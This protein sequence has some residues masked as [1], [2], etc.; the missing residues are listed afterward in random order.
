M[1]T[2]EQINSIKKAVSEDDDRM[3]IILGVLGDPGRYRI[4]KILMDHHNICVT[5]IAA[6]LGTT[7]SAASQQLR[8]LERIGVIR[9]ER[10]GQMICYEI[11]DD[12]PLVKSLCKLF[13]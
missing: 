13:S 6:I 3:P 1:L 4:F 12:D 8:I 5:E 11:K 2:K 10:M 9:K 7:V